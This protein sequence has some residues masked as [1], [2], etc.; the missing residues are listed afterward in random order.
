M[1]VFPKNY[2]K[3]PEDRIHLF[4]RNVDVNE[5]NEQFLEDLDGE[6]F[7]V[8]AFVQHPT[9]KNYKPKIENTG[10][11][12]NTNLQKVFKFNPKSL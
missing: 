2:D 3:I 5:K 12:A 9:L 6:M 10:N 1:R 8:E 7:E 4:V 11:I